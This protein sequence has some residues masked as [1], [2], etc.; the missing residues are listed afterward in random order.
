M[1]TAVII[2]DELDS[3]NVLN[4]LLKHFTTAPIKVVGTA[5][6]LEDGIK[7]IN[8]TKPDVVFLDIN[9]PNQNGMDIYKYYQ[10][11]DF[12]II[13]I[14]AYNQYAIEAL[15]NSATDYLL[16][17]VSFIELRETINKVASIIEQEQKHREVEDKANL[18]CTPEMEGKNVVLNVEDGF[19]LENSKNIEY[20]YANESYSVIV[21]YMGKKITITKTLKDLEELLPA[22]Q[23]Y[24]THKSYLVNIY[25]IR[26]F[27]K[28][29]ES[30]VLLRSGIKIPVSVRKS[31]AIANEIKNLLIS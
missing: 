5:N 12:K 27:V 10:T 15:K 23:F 7:T 2:D 17:P 16:K 19:I 13:F 24:R 22:N 21:T 29:N 14:T 30:F 11:P 28:A 4:Q 25:Y 18:L 26:K 1:L 9:M 31:S 8:S 6:N 3:V 20:C